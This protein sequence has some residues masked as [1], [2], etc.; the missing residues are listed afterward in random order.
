MTQ[1]LRDMTD[2]DDPAVSELIDLVRSAGELDPPA[3]AQERVR[4]VLVLPR[5]QRSRFRQPLMVA[6]AL[7]V[8]VP[9]AVASVK[10]L[11]AP[12]LPAPPPVPRLEPVRTPRPRGAPPEPVLTAMPESV[13]LAA[14][15]SDDDSIHLVPQ[16]EIP[17]RVAIAAPAR[18]P[19][20]AP[21]VA[22]PPAALKPAAPQ[23]AEV[24]APAP[25][26]SAP[27]PAPLASRSVPEFRG[28]PPDR[29]APPTPTPTPPS[30]SAS[31]GEPRMPL[32][33]PGPRPALTLRPAP[34]PAR[35]PAPQPDES[36]LVLGALHRLRHDHDARGAL[37]Q[38]DEYRARFPGGDLAE[39]S[40]ALMIEAR[41]AL[42]D[43][44][45]GALAAEYMQRY[46][47]GRFRAA[48]ERALRRFAPP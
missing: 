30:A 20:A 34:A 32:R 18:P 40:L 23:P 41:A 42:D 16:P 38:L 12:R 48:A 15:I 29:A 17:A 13:W 9:V 10:R 6:L 25:T 33:P 46:P 36:V 26:V 11:V 24:H 1:R 37:V 43:R 19:I 4:R 39:E 5:P 35:A 2:C 31:Q 28:W 21:T 45:A 22:S 27:P 3:G 14:S 44:Q 8:V 7:L 47:Q